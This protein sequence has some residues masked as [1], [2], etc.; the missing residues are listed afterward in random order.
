MAKTRVKRTDKDDED[1]SPT[2]VVKLKKTGESW[3]NKV[4]VAW[5][6]TTKSGKT[7]FSMKPSRGY[8]IRW[9]DFYDGGQYA[10]LIFPED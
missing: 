7:F 2:H 4:G 5:Q 10:L 9:K 1:P 3:S 8:D 6:K